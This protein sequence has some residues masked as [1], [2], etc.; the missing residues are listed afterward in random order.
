[1]LFRRYLR[2]FPVVPF[3]GPGSARKRPVYSDDV[4]DGLSR[5]VGNEIGARVRPQIDQAKKKIESMNTSA[6]AFIKENPGKCVVGAIA[7]GFLIGKIASRR[8]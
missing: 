3:I 2:R 6:V 8:G 1:M 4:V 7:L 5:I